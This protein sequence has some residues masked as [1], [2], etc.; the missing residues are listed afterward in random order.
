LATIV[1]PVFEELGVG[2]ALHVSSTAR[3]FEQWYPL[4]IPTGVMQFEYDFAVANRRWRYNSVCLVRARRERAPLLGRHAGFSDFFVP[5]GAVE[6]AFGTLV[7]GPFATARPTSADVL[8][9]WRAL[10]GGHGHLGDPA[11]A[12]YVSSTLSTLTLD[13]AML[14]DFRRLLI[15]MAQL[16]QV[17]TPPEAIGTDIARL[18]DRLAHARAAERMWRSTRTMIDVRTTGQWANDANE[19]FRIGLKKMP[20][21]VIVGLVVGGDDANPVG[22]V[23][24]RDAFLRE[25]V[26]LA[27]RRGGT[28]CTRIGDHGVV[29]LS[30]QTAS[31]GRLRSILE[32]L[33]N[34]IRQA[35]RRFGLRVHFG[36]SATATAPALP[37]RYR[38]ALSAAEKA[39]SQQLPIVHGASPG[40]FGTSPLGELRSQLG[41]AVTSSPSDLAARFQHYME[42]AAAHCGYGLESTRAHLE[43]GF[44]EIAEALA[45]SGAVD[46]RG[47]AEIRSTLERSAAEANTVAQVFATYRTVIG[48]VGH[49]LVQP[50]SAR[51]ERS[52]QRAVDFIREHLAEPLTLAKVSRVA[53]FAPHYF[54]RLFAKTQ[55]M[56][57]RQYVRRLRLDRAKS[58]LVASTLS[59]QRI[60]NL[61]GFGAR[62]HFQKAFKDAF[63]VTPREYRNRGVLL[64]ERA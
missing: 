30:D 15:S 9:R 1:A 55:N 4:F 31:G 21:Q 33:S 16:F 56:T 63:G 38:T 40:R 52:I 29:F 37:T 58:M 49:A 36:T 10:S 62:A 19:L 20:E 23:L 11:F 24:G 2:A 42:A 6:S 54:C 22:R 35:A 50:R 26:E 14:A 43:A 61:S 57:L 8:A 59:V 39:L 34:R 7:A 12:D 18:R 5:V 44:D 13:A 17:E 48:S 46:E 27:R 25:C 53:G 51:H 60:G 64:R 41:Q 47:F 28:V 32:E 45:T 3:T